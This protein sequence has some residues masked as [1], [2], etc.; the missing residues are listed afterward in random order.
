MTEDCGN[1]YS[2][3]GTDR[4]GEVKELTTMH[5]QLVPRPVHKSACV[6]RRPRLGARWFCTTRTATLGTQNQ[7]WRFA[8]I[9]VAIPTTAGALDVL[10]KWPFFDHALIR[11]ILHGTAGAGKHGQGPSH[12]ARSS[13][14]PRVGDGLVEGHS[15]SR[16]NRQK[17]SDDVFA[18]VRYM[19]PLIAAHRV[20]A[21]DN[22]LN[23]L[24]IR[25]SVEWGSSGNNNVENHS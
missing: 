15:A 10:I 9:P 2:A 13:D 22:L 6:C 18:F 1:R 19:S 25:L 12:A 7:S 4:R 11:R 3:G 20:R 24:P 21:S 16:I 8:L 14:K 23:N 5:R 17:A